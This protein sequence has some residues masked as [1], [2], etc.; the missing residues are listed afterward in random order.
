DVITAK[1]IKGARDD[2]SKEILIPAGATVRGRIVRVKHLL[3]SLSFQFAFVL[4]T[5]EVNGSS[6]P[7]VAKLDRTNELDPR[8]RPSTLMQRMVAIIL[9]PAGEPITVG[10]FLFRTLDGSFVFPRNFES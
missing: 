8:I 5:L 9:P 1:V 7:L 2:R 3:N 4:E 6:S 10:S